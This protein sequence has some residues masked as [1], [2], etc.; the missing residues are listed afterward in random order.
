MTE[1][2]NLPF[3]SVMI[4]TYNP[5]PQYLEQT[6]R[7]VLA[8]DPGPERMQI[9]VVD[10][11]STNVDVSALVMDIAGERITFSRNAQNLGLA[12]CWNS[13]VERSRGE[14]IH[15]LHQD[16]YVHE[17]FYK[18]LRCLAELHP[19][20]GLLATRS[21]TV[22][23]NGVIISVTS[24]VPSLEKGGNVIEEF[25]YQTPIL[26]PGV[27]MRRCCYEEVGGFRADLKFT[28]DLE[29]WTRAIKAKSGLVTSDVLAYYRTYSQNQSR[30]LWRSGEVLP[31]I[32]KLNALFAD[33]YE[34]FD[35]M[36]A[37]RGLME[38]ARYWE[39]RMQ[40]LGEIE[41]ARACREYWKMNA[42]IDFRFRVFVKNLIRH[43]NRL[44]VK[45]IQGASKLRNR[46]SPSLG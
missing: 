15:I 21:F 34:D 25:F 28:L 9:E 19:R 29:M 14:W 45:L 37:H 5:R 40:Q 30:R 23:E 35:A 33:T 36:K 1:I 12:G 10:D 4:P 46:N 22:D 24:R 42:P 43:M 39:V 8:Q 26:C 13:C 2:T 44:L 11:C 17:G 16:D 32:A 7:S 6:L 18:H 38:T 27:V 31:D 41:V 3:W 20:V